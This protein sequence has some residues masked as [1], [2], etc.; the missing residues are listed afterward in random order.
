MKFANTAML[1]LN[2]ENI[3]SRYGFGSPLYGNRFSLSKFGILS[4]GFG[5]LLSKFGILSYG[6]G[7]LLS[8]FGILSYGFGILLAGFRISSDGFGISRFHTKNAPVVEKE[9]L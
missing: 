6:F 2:I 1:F 8:K 7:I 4:D 9:Y 3:T 5:I